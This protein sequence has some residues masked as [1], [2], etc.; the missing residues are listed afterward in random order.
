MSL[1]NGKAV[2]SELK[3]VA[4]VEDETETD[5]ET[6]GHQQGRSYLNASTVRTCVLGKKCEFITSAHA[7]VDFLQ[8]ARH[9][10]G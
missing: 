2:K 7:N 4:S 1:G 6:S 8:R 10:I 3:M 9:A 5:S